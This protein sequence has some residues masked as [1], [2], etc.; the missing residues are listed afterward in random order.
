M[1]QMSIPPIRKVD[2]SRDLHTI[3]SIA[4]SVVK[5]TRHTWGTYGTL[6]WTSVAT[7]SRNSGSFAPGRLTIQ[8][9][10]HAKYSS[11]FGRAE[12]IDAPTGMM[13]LGQKLPSRTLKK[14][15]FS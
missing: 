14:L 7:T 4:Q 3:K 12:N 15:G 9:D 6:S 1:V 8:K 13:S 11:G 10:T 2:A 5:P